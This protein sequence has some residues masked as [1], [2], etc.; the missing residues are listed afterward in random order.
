MDRE[1]HARVAIPGDPD[2]ARGDL[3]LAAK[4]RLLGL[5]GRPDREVLD[6][7][8]PRRSVVEHE[9][10]GAEHDEAEGGK[11]E[12]S[13]RISNTSARPGWSAT[14]AVV[15]RGSRRSKA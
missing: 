1:G 9:D 12:R 3:G 4:S 6:G 11:D 8:L 15:S 7:G 5:A 14:A 2:G 10:R 13:R